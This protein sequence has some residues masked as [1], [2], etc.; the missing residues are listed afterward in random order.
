MP[1][2]N[3]EHSCPAKREVDWPL[4][5]MELRYYADQPT[6][7]RRV[8][9]SEDARFQWRMWVSR[10]YVANDVDFCPLGLQT[11]HLADVDRR[12][13]EFSAAALAEVFEAHYVQYTTRIPFLLTILSGWPLFRIY[14]GLVDSARARPDFPHLPSKGICGGAVQ[15]GDVFSAIRLLQGAEGLSSDDGKHVLTILARILTNAEA[16]AAQMSETSGRADWDAAEDDCNLAVAFAHLGRAWVLA[17]FRD[18]S[19]STAHG[20]TQYF[21]KLLQSIEAAEEAWHLSAEAAVRKH[22]QD[23]N[24]LLRVYA[25][26]WPIWQLLD[27]LQIL[28]SQAPWAL[29]CRSFSEKAPL[30]PACAVPQQAEWNRESQW[31]SALAAGG[32]RGEFEAVVQPRLRMDLLQDMAGSTAA[33]A[34]RALDHRLEHAGEAWATLLSDDDAIANEA[35]RR[36]LLVYTEAVRVMARSVRQAEAKVA[37]DA[38]K[39]APAR[40]FLV[41]MTEAAFTSDVRAMLEGDGLTPLVMPSFSS[42]GITVPSRRKQRG[43]IGAQEEETSENL[44]EVE[45]VELSWWLKIKL[46]KLTEYRRIVYLDADTLVHRP[47]DELFA[48]PDE[49]ALA[50]PA[51]L[52][53]DGKGSEISV[54]V[55]S[56]RPDRRIYDAFVSFLS[57]AADRFVTGVRSVDQMLQ[58]SFFAQHFSWAGYPRWEAGSGQFLGCMEDLPTLSPGEVTDSQDHFKGV[59]APLGKVC[60]LPPRYDFCVSYPALVA[61]MDSPDFQEAE[62]A[63]QFPQPGEQPVEKNLEGLLRARLLHWTGPRRKPW[64]HYLSL[65]RTTFDNLWWQAHAE[66]CQEARDDKRDESKRLMQPCRFDCESL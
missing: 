63:V 41:L 27:R 28:T 32:A 16:A 10:V 30:C 56:L 44:S 49:I 22:H 4:L 66:L 46:W 19:E 15:I 13:E 33:A 61:G 39:V 21:G 57:A 14:S 29:Q 2:Y 62:L 31:V 43:E 45:Q 65:S 5:K 17:S 7:Q 8:F 12:F 59:K 9:V 60:V 1:F 40:P 48:L 6:W 18:F 24:A 53:R 25:G 42:E 34:A 35:A 36:A 3:P 11:V 64:M 55:M 58:H 23:N 52:S 26:G 37:F 51:H 54:G 50:A 20:L 47:I 38:S